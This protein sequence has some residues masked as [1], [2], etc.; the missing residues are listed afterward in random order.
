MS[1]KILMSSLSDQL[2]KAGLVTEEQVKKAAE[3]PKTQK[4]KGKSKH[5]P[6][7]KTPNK[8]RPHS[9]NE[10]SDLANFYKQ[11]ATIEKTEKREAEKKKQEAARLKKE[12]NEKINKLLTENLVN[13]D[14][15]DIRYNFVVGT[16]IKYLFVTEKQQQKLA[17]GELAISFLGGKRA[18][19]PVNIAKQILKL[20]P[21]KIVVISDPSKE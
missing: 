16:T 6:H 20:N 4:P 21:N 2:L 8:K 17:D 3:K 10:P 1:Y 13:E 11:R 15:A 7:N 12:T 18:L 19:I 14:A 9:K 5:K